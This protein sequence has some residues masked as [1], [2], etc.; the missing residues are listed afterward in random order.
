[1]TT[2]A[3]AYA[4][5]LSAAEQVL[6]DY[7]A[8]LGPRCSETQNR[9]RNT[10]RDFLACCSNAPE[11]PGAPLI[12]D[13]QRFLRCLIRACTG[14]VFAYARQR[15]EI[16]SRYSRALYRAGLLETDLMAELKTSQGLTSCGRLATA[17][18]SSDPEAALAALQAAT[19][20]PLPGPLAAVIHSYIELRQSLGLKGNAVRS[21]LL[22]LDR[23]AQ[24]QGIA[25][26]NALRPVV[27]EQWMKSMT[28]IAVVRIQ[29]ARCVKR[30]FDHLCS[31]QLVAGNPVPTS[32][33]ALGKQP[34]ASIKPFIFTK[35][36][37][38]AI[39]DEARRLPDS[40][41][42]QCRAQTCSTM[43][44]LLYALGLRHGEVGRL[45]IRNVDLA[46]QTLFI[47]L[48]KFYKSRYVPFGPKV[49]QCLQQFLEVRRT[50]LAPAKEDDPLFVTRSRVPL[51]RSTLRAAFL[52]I[53]QRVGIR[54]SEGQRA[55]RLHDA[56]HSFAVNRL[57]RW[58]REG[59]DVQSRLPLLSTFLGHVDVHS[60][61]VYLTVTAD[62]LR[63][64][65]DRFHRHFGSLFDEER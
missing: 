53:L 45:R 11:Q 48:T 62:L 44:T 15:L 27:I 49:A 38:A 30:F 23:F 12:L 8:A 25:S 41:K 10:I 40:K 63:E 50:E 9:H 2:T 37:I 32:M 61:Q 35:E 24:A 4:V 36:Q 55:P 65:N 47:D 18:Q 19:Q 60:T 64:A 33:L 46:A 16:L 28:L 5:A 21:T 31:L 59:V 54:R 22:D 42:F 29:K 7:L 34:N 39:L 1:M 20:P 57:L 26:L 43:L 58:Y 52:D 17:L 14:T 13:G 3:K 6:A 51:H 56:R